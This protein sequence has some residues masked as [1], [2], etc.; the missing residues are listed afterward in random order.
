MEG[1]RF[2]LWVLAKSIQTLANRQPYEMEFCCT[3]QPTVTST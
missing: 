3:H 1:A 2:G